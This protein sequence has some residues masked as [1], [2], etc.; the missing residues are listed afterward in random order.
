MDPLLVLDGE[1]PMV[2]D[3]GDDMLVGDEQGVEARLDV[4]DIFMCW[5][6]GVWFFLA[7]DGQ[8]SDW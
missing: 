6:F 1:N 8:K 4:Q 3:R 2:M 7:V 5:F